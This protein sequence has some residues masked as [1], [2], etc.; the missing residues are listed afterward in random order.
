MSQLRDLVDT[1]R[2]R[3]V[4]HLFDQ[5]NVHFV[6]DSFILHRVGQNFMHPLVEFTGVA[7]THVPIYMHTHT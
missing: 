7:L 5:R 3:V 4:G 2:K 6:P 1:S